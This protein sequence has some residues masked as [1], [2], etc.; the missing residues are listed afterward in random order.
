MPASSAN[1]RAAR[2]RPRTEPALRVRP[3]ERRDLPTLVEHRRR[4]FREIGRWSAEALARSAEAYRR[5]SL[6][7]RAARRWFGFVVEDPDAG[8]VGSG[9][10]WL[11]PS[12]PRPSP[13]AR[14][15][16]PYIMSMYTE[17]RFRG[18]GIASRLVETMVTWATDRGYRRIFLH[19]SRMGR[20]VYARLGFEVGNEMRLE[21]P[22][23]RRRRR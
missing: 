23:R 18:R 5:W 16:M 7:E 9:V 2:S 1:R 11:Q 17:P 19:A 15:W 21:L 4:M 3:A 13:L 22:A 12:Q 6:R 8:I 14:L 10:L 20:P